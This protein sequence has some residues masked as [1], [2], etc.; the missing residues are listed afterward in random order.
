MAYMQRY[1]DECR[2]QMTNEDE[3]LAVDVLVDAMKAPC[4]Q[5]GT[6]AG[7]LGEMVFEKVKG[8]EWGYGLNAKTLEYEDLLEAVRPTWRQRGLG[9][10]VEGEEGAGDQGA[11]G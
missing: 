5:I 10:R 4:I 11:Q 3:A 6:N 8:Q 1:A 9:G 2:E 7:L